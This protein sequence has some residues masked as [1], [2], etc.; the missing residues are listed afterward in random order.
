[1][2]TASRRQR[3]DTAP[4]PSEPG[5]R[6]LLEMLPAA[7]YTCDA[8]GLITYFNER[9][10]EL[11][12]RRPKLNDSVDRFCGSFKLYAAD[13]SPVRHDLCWMALALRDRQSYNG[14]EIV[15]ERPDGTRHTVLAYASPMHDESGEI[16]GAVNVLVDITDRK[17]MEEALRASET[18]LRTVVDTT[19]DCIKTVAPDG[20]IV[21]MNSAG[22]EIFETEQSDHI[23]GR[24]IFPLIAEEDRQAYRDFHDRICQGERGTL[25]YELAVLKGTRRRMETRA[26]PLQAVDGSFLHLAI[27][28]DV[29][30]ERRNRE[31]LREADRRKDEF[32]AMLAHELRNP[33][34]PVR[35][36]ATLLGME[37]LD[38]ESTG[39]ARDIL[40][41]Q[42]DHLARL[43]DDLLDVSRIVQGKI[44]LRKEPVQLAN[45]VARAVEVSRPLIRERGHEFTVSLPV[46]PVWLEA[47]PVRLS[48]VVSNLLNNAAKYTPRGGH[49]RLSAAREADADGVAIHVHDT[50]AGIAP[51]LLPHV[52]DLFV[53]GDSSIDRAHGGLGIGLTLVKNLVE[54][55]DGSVLVRSAGVGRG[56][57][58]TVHL[59][60]IVPT[61]A[62]DQRPFVPAMVRPLRVLVIE[63][64][65][66][67]AKILARMLEK[68]WGHEVQIA[69]DGAT[70]IDV[71][72]A[73]RPDLVLCDIGLPHMSGYDVARRLRALAEA[74]G[75]LLV[76]L[77][78]YGAEADRRRSTEAGFDEHLVKPA[79]VE[80]LQR[81]FSHPKLSVRAMKDD[82]SNDADEENDVPQEQ[83]ETDDAAR[84]LESLSDIL[85]PGD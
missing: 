60:T 85:D 45:V 55:H 9:A 69:Y 36:A 5:V 27:T 68:F 17:R 23:V 59:P 2:T 50:G 40:I 49:V 29:T 3:A 13:G 10:A 80:T 34:A 18:H 8:D 20:T 21:S 35:T 63:D 73:F 41:K 58:F 64:N 47:D 38:A 28:R 61:T 12:G 53:Q 72:S 31:A 22:L 4:R 43:V 25:E 76:A 46:E 14:Q 32:L 83:W 1:M 74:S 15:A 33:L 11:W 54:L 44:D 48:Q 77:T 26:V 57:E 67:S 65:I 24:S 7:A 52:F 51:E 39:E 37:G 16:V 71:A 79:G 75:A 66:G 81:L 6:Q 42:V 78:G 62:P 30:E 70:A 84:P 56:S 19:P 82:Q